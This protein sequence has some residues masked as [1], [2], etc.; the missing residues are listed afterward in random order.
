MDLER[1]DSDM[2][3]FEFDCD[4][5]DMNMNSD[6]VRLDN[7]PCDIDGHATRKWIVTWLNLTMIQA[8]WI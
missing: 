5:C 6:I 7:D 4:P 1:M 3:Y 8:T 2:Y